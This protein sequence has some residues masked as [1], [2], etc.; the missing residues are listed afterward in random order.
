MSGWP[1]YKRAACLKRF[2]DLDRIET[3]QL[4]GTAAR[5]APLETNSAIQYTMDIQAALKRL[6]PRQSQ[7]IVSRFG[8]GGKSETL[9]EIGQSMNLTRERI[10]QIESKAL[11]RLFLFL[12]KTALDK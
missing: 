1:Y 12:K 5:Q 7:I 8:F 10:R 9:E 2:S 4:N 3:M 6:K 11:Q